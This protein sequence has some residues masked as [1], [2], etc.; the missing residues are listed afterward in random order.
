MF[1]KK[2]NQL[3]DTQTHPDSFDYIKPK[4]KRVSYKSFAKGK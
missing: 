3:C 1:Q 4:Y 2:M